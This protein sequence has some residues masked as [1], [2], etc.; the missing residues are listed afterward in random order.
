MSEGETYHDNPST[1][2]DEES[3]IKILIASD[4]H[5]GYD[6]LNQ[7][8][9]NDS[10][11][12]FEEILMIANS[13]DVDFILLAGDLFHKAQPSTNSLNRCIQLL[14]THSLGN[15]EIQFEVKD[16]KTGEIMQFQV[17]TNENK[18]E[19]NYNFPINIDD[20]NIKVSHPVFAI[21]GCHDDVVNNLSAI[22]VLNSSGLVNYFGKWKDFCEVNLEPFII[23]KD[24]IKIA[25][26][27]LSHIPDRKLFDLFANDKVNVKFPDQVND[28][29]NILTIHQN[30]IEKGKNNFIP[31]DMLPKFMNLIIWGHEH[32]CKIDIEQCNDKMFIT[33]P[34]SSIA[35]SLN[36]SEAVRK[37]VGILEIN[38]RPLIY[39]SIELNYD[40]ENVE[41]FLTNSVIEMINEAKELLTG[42]SHQPT[43][44]LIR[45]R[46][47]YVNPDHLINTRRF[48]QKFDEL[49]AKSEEILQFRKA[50]RRNRQEKL[51]IDENILRNSKIDDDNNRV[52]DSVDEYFE[53]DKNK[54]S[55]FNFKCLSDVVRLLVDKDDQ[56]GAEKVIQAQINAA[57]EYF[58][59]KLGD[60]ESINIAH[61][62]R[63][64]KSFDVHEKIF[65]SLKV[66]KKNSK[67]AQNE[68]SDSDEDSDV[69]MIDGDK[70][71]NRSL[72]KRPQDKPGTSSASKR[73]RG[74]S[75]NKR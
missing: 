70:I 45:L 7:E 65:E 31:V 32:E 36:Q 19:E 64:N 57:T 18:S 1:D 26:Y 68:D 29:Y 71:K 41:E 43:K 6:E 48:G 75:N 47:Q 58:I 56:D 10:F 40:D 72:L 4:I 12:T 63:E 53:K 69:V 17:I 11:K 34:G 52:E 9:G 55:L 44:P 23:C 22:D 3:K 13:Q 5:L 42:H 73:G 15:K 30:R 35:T 51:R 25:L 33:Q 14:R 60:E 20:D 49:I 50:S 38:I 62:F 61:E 27:G 54:L 2:Q 37:H 59:E 16:S 74:S 8:T 28:F 39:K 66:P 24:K 21:H 46:V 67:T